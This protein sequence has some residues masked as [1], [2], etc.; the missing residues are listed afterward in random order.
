MNN[1][2]LSI[3]NSLRSEMSLGLVKRLYSNEYHFN[4]YCTFQYPENRFGI[5][6]SY[7]NNIHFNLQPFEHLSGLKVA[8]YSDDSFKNCNL[9]SV[10]LYNI[11][12]EDI[13]A[14][15]CENLIAKIANQTDIKTAITIF[16]NTLLRWK[17][18]FER[19]N[20]GGLTKEEQQGLYGE[21]NF[22][23]KCLNSGLIPNF[24]IIQY[25]TGVDKSLRDFQGSD[26]AVE[27]KTTSTNNPQELTINGE[28]QLDDTMIDNL[29]LY[30]CSVEV[31]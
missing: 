15:L 30:H 25:Y 22:L 1:M 2:V 4:L 8:I 29:Y 10:Q 19:K 21:L 5:A 7:P 24:E 14:Y 28:R 11:V 17:N 16:G 31:S 26:W 18:L 3:W 27:V 6:L 20:S 12:D 13:F 9:L 23:H